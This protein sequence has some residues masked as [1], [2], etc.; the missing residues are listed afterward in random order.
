MSERMNRLLTGQLAEPKRLLIV[1]DEP[2]VRDQLARWFAADGHIC[3]TTETAERAEE[4]L[5]QETFSLVISDITLPGK[6]GIDLL[7][8]VKERFSD[9]AFVVATALDDRASAIRAL[10]MGAYGYVVKPFKRNEV[11]ISVVNAL[12][13]RRL[14]LAQR[15]HE[16]HLE[17]TIRSQTQDIRASRREIALRLMAAQEYR[18]DETG[19]HIRRIGLY[20]EMVGLRLGLSKDDAEMLGLAA[21]MHD[22]G[23]IGVPDAI[24]MKPGGLTPK[25]R[26]IMKTHA[27]IGGCILEG[28]QIPLLNMSRDVALGHHEKWDGSGYPLG[29]SGG[30]IPEAARTVA[31]LDVYDALVH[32]R[33]YRPAMSEEDAL[34]IMEQERESSFDPDIFDAFLAELPTVR[35]VRQRVQG[36]GRG[37]TSDAS[38]VAAG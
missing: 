21:P 20:A 4:C 29:L 8:A 15:D 22:V 5:E 17:G 9:V 25:E 18:H 37:A 3:E 2:A 35:Q 27:A 7:T 34:Q 23:K 33:A 36:P 19:S 14:L 32:E 16:R 12:E 38:P 24:L 28:T 26:T 1:D 13:R 10:E 31:V 6:S 30:E 11:T